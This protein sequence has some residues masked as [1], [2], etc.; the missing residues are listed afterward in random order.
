MGD[1]KKLIRP[2]TIGTRIPVDSQA[3]VSE[4]IFSKLFCFVE[5]LEQR[6]DLNAG[7]QLRFNIV[8]NNLQVFY[9]V[10]HIGNV[11][12]P[13]KEFLIKIINEGHKI[14]GT[15]REVKQVDQLPTKLTVLVENL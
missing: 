10:Q 8:D 2:Y 13:Q 12:S 11:L 7:K 9:G 1:S 5:C 4:Q 3:Q 15:I 14:I 6:N